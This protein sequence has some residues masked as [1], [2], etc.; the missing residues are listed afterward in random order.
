MIDLR[1]FLANAK[2]DSP[3]VIA[4]M[5]QRATFP[6]R[7][8]SNGRT[9]IVTS[10][11]DDFG[12][13]FSRCGSWDAWARDVVQGIDYLSREPRYHGFVV[14]TL[15]CGAATANIIRGALG[16]G[17]PVLRLDGA[18]LIIVKECSKVAERDWK[19]GWELR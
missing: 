7:K 10:G 16:V 5:I 17:K 8:I 18:E 6:L 11:L 9:V 15:R 1:V 12:R 3:E 13:H 2:G 4:D 19:A 14:P